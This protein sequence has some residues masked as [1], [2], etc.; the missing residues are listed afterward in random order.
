MN[1]LRFRGW[2]LLAL[3]LLLAFMGCTRRPAEPAIKAGMYQGTESDLKRLWTDILVAC[4]KDQRTRVHDL[5]ASFLLTP[6]ELAGLFGPAR[7]QEL[8]PR[9]RAMLGSIANAGAVELVAH[10]YEKKY[11]DIAVRRIDTLPA[12]EQ[13]EPDRN[14]LQSLLTSQPIYTVRVKRKTEDRGLRYDFFI[15]IN[16]YWRSG[17]LIGKYLPAAPPP[18][19]APAPGASAPDAAPA[20]ASAASSQP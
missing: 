1:A 19:A 8:L 20:P 18:N 15:Y 9:Y 2:R 4:Q 7:A 5:M 12:A 16:G 11:D 13:T 10:V 6:E 3:S 17:N 14:V